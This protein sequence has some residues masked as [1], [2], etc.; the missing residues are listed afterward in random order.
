MATPKTGHY[1]A[2]KTARQTFIPLLSLSIPLATYRAFLAI[3][4]E[5][6]KG[7]WNRYAPRNQRLLSAPVT[8]NRATL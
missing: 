6:S 2:V 8:P 5:G 1:P 4:F 3:R 7:A